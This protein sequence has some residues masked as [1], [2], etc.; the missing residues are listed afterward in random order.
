MKHKIFISLFFFAITSICTA[1][2]KNPA[3]WSFSS[4]AKGADTYEVHFVVT[5]EKG[6]HIYSQSTPDG[7]PVAT[8]FTFSKN[9]LIILQDKIK[10]VGR[11]EQHHEPLF[12]VDVKQ[13]SDRVDFVQI[14][15]IRKGI[16]T[17]LTGSIEYM[18]CNDSECLPP[19]RNKFSIG[20]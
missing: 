20:L 11:L 12:G 7:G 4:K 19:T 15:K 17:M 18:L 3:K 10:E 16:K 13:Y 6:W 9:P 1:Q 5:I 8:S 2:V 14:V